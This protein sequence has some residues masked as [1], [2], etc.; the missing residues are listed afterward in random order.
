MFFQPHAHNSDFGYSTHRGPAMFQA[1]HTP[2]YHS[3]G[4]RVC[5]GPTHAN[6][7]TI[8]YNTV[9]YPLRPTGP[10][11]PQAMSFQPQAAPI[12]FNQHPYVPM[13]MFVREEMEPWTEYEMEYEMGLFQGQAAGQYAGYGYQQGYG[14]QGYGQQGYGQQ[15]YG[16]QGY[17]QQGYFQPGYGYY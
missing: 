5:Y 13:P 10:Y 14:Q 17:G 9:Q 4:S 12:Q 2:H 11:N 15:G 1:S 7:S 3:D 6:P 16:Q 8:N